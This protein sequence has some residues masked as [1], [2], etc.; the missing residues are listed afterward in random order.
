L[1]VALAAVV[2]FAAFF[3]ARKRRSQK[4]RER[5]GPEYDRV[6]RQEGDVRRGEA[7][8]DFRARRREKLVIHSLTPSSRS[9]FAEHWRTVQAQ[10]VDDPKNAVTRADRLVN[11]V[12]QAR[13][14]PVED[15]AQQASI[16]SVD[17]P[18]V[19]DNYRSAHDIAARH[20][21][22]EAS[23][24]DLRRAMVHYRSLFDELLAE[25]TLH[26]KGA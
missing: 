10:F 6:V 18:I 4:L 11:E 8:L 3:V 1:W 22:G 26:R 15:F 12:M 16:I 24:E 23:T 21:R 14:Y 20:R 5:F 7:V 19:V 2:A 17:Y 25:S 13:G 9:D